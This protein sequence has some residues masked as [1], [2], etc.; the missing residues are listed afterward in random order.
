[1]GNENF[2]QVSGH[3]VVVGKEGREGKR[4]VHIADA[5]KITS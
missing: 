1:M 4:E 3:S 2:K 5:I